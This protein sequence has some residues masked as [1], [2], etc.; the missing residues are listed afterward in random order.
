ME[1]FL[2]ILLFLGLYIGSITIPEARMATSTNKLRALVVYSSTSYFLYKG[3]TMGFEY[4]L[5]NH[6]AAQQGM[7]LEIVVSDG[8]ESLIPDL[9]A[10]KGDLIAHGLN[11]TS[12]RMNKIQFTDTV[13]MTKQVLVQRKPENWQSIPSAKL[14]EILVSNYRDLLGD[15][16]TVARGTSYEERLRKFIDSIGGGIHV[17]LLDP[18]YSKGEL[19]EMVNDGIIQY[20]IAE[21]YIAGINASWMSDLDVSVALTPEEPIAWAVRPGETELL[22]VLNEGVKKSKSSTTYA[23]IYNKYFKNQKYFKTRIKS[24]FYSLK[25]NQISPFDKIVK[26]EAAGIGWDWRLVSSVIYQESRFDPKVNA[27]SGAVG[28]MQ[29]MP[30]TAASLGVNDLTDPAQ[31]IAGGCRYL[32]QLFE[33]FDEV[34][35]SVQ[36]MKFTLASYNCGSGHVFDAQRLA[37]SRGMNRNWWDGNVEICLKELSDP[38]NYTL[39]MIKYGYVKGRQPYNYV[40]DIFQ[41][42]DHYSFFINK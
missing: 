14:Q 5:L 23:V 13:I 24:P 29:L 21:E 33:R 20:T 37:D 41:R 17:Q 28:L 27:W 10:G 2:F 30:K 35:D 40:R 3:E 39:P 8:I 4:E 7:D 1:R 9:L 31:N 36:R 6:L 42:Y 22:Q 16:L 12:E 38:E 18:K 25:N 19:I 26:E 34:K 32:A 15:T 11:I